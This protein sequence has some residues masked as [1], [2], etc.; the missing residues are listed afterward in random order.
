MSKKHY[1]LAIIGGGMSGLMLAH[2]LSNLNENLKILI[3]EKGKD[4]KKRSCPIIEGFTNHCINCR[5]CAIMTGL[6]GAG[7]FSDGKFTI[8]NEFGGWLSEFIGQKQALAYME[9]ADD[10]LVSLG[11]TEYRYKPDNKLKQLCLEND[12]FMKQGDI[13]HLGTDNTYKIMLG[14]IDE[15]RTKCTILSEVEVLDV[16]KDKGIIKTSNN[17]E[18]MADHIVFAVG[19]SGSSFLTNWCLNN[20]IELSVNQVDIGVRVELPAEIWKDISNK[21]YDPKISYDSKQYGDP[22]RM[23]C[24]NDRGNVVSENTNGIITVN[25][26][27]YNDPKRKTNNSNFAL[28]SS[29]KFTDEFVNPTQY[30][31]NVSRSA[32]LIGGGNVVVQRFGDL[33]AGQRTTKIRLEQSLVTPTLDASPGDLSL[34]LPKRQLDNII[35]TI[36][37]LDKIAPGTANYDTLLYGVE[38]K[39][40]SSRPKTNDFEID[41]CKNIYACGDGAGITRSLAQ[42]AANGLYLADKLYK[43]LK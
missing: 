23:F 42:A 9:E 24:F 13:K 43:E 8:T 38:C 2:R 40:Y 18:F 30:I 31:E 32:N 20:D 26:H 15:I 25:G 27:A 36:L 1:D 21:V 7:A 10:I 22:T 34:C 16:D 39:Y 41:K 33:L 14:L 28:L 37:Q 4:L 11:A 29:I 5:Q 6:A 12:L 17:E 19:R 3:L 35:E